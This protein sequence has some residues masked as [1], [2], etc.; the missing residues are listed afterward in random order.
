MRIKNAFVLRSA[1]AKQHQWLTNAE[2][3]SGLGLHRNTV[4]QLLKARPVSAATV[5]RAAE[6][7]GK[8]PLEIAEF[9]V[10][11]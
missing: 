6:A 5:R 8:E 9:I 10:E 11:E 4:Q 3:A 7:I 2:I 1:F